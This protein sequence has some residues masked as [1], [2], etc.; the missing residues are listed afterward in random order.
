MV[1]EVRDM[2]GRTVLS[3][4]LSEGQN[5]LNISTVGL[6]NGVFIY[7]IIENGVVLATRKLTIQK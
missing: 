5:S 2:L 1:F 6:D 4:K 7:H 3:S